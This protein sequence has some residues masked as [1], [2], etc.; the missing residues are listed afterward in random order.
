MCGLSS[1]WGISPFKGACQ[2]SWETI[3]GYDRCMSFR[4]KPPLGRHFEDGSGRGSLADRLDAVRSASSVRADVTTEMPIIRAPLAPDRAGGEPPRRRRGTSRADRVRQTGQHPA[5]RQSPDQ[6]RARPDNQSD[7]RPEDR[8]RHQEQPGRRGNPAQADRQQNV[9]EES[10]QQTVGSTAGKSVA[11][12]SAVM[13]MGTFASR[14]LGLVRSPILLGA[15][16]AIS[17]PAGNAFDVANKVPNLIYMAIVGGLVN[18]V[19]VPAIV[20]ATKQSDDD[21]QSFI[22]KLLTV[23]I[24]ILGAAT[25]AITLAA[26]LVVKLFA[27]TMSGPWYDLTVA[28]AL[29]C[30]PQIFFYG[31]YTVLGQIL[32]AR[33]NFG[34]YMW[35]PV[36]NNV[37]AIGGLLIILWVYGGYDPATA[38]SPEIWTGARIG[39]LG[40]FHTLGIVAQALVLIWP[41]RKMGFTYRPDFQWRD[42]GL[43]SAARASWWI[44]LST[45]GGMVPT[46]FLSNVAAGATARAQVQGIPTEEVAGNFVYTVGYT[47]YSIPTSLIVVSIS[48]AMFTRLARNAANNDMVAM[49]ADTSKT[50][51]M[52]STL[53]FLCTGLLVVLAVPISR[54]IAATS[55]PT[56]VFT[57]SR[58]VIAMSI[59]LVGIGAVNILD[60]AFYAFEDTRRAFY[61]NLPFQL[62]GLVGFTLCGLLPP[63]WVVVGIGLV[64]SATNIG[65]V[66]L[67]AHV[68]GKKMDGIDGK[69]LLTTHAKLLGITAFIVFVGWLWMRWLS[70]GLH[71]EGDI[72]AS[73]LIIIVV[74][75]V[76]TL[77]YL[78]LMKLLR[79]PELNSLAG[80]V[81]GILRKFGIKR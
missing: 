75:P 39:M 78:G 79:M 20:R 54:I 70:G 62:A 61:L 3:T 28:F 59:G 11:R 25:L 43:G 67:L 65:S 53:M 6:R 58:V 69:R 27:A 64:M 72:L 21:G 33:E 9:S 8:P 76:L 2:L 26:P 56:E 55:S 42:S 17:A 66:F 13:F 1:A 5:V 71:P 7:T 30:L 41:L 68:L 35:A 80:P 49:R 24:V 18:A 46:M 45:V 63:G 12:S 81:R 57:L 4:P 47:I 74:A 60:R 32:N 10:S 34:P 44:L 31:M 77:V 73:L 15:V 38:E 36:L 37:V 50:L 48:T 40:G 52:V 19:L 51:R 14:L 16:V 22:N 23:A 29:W